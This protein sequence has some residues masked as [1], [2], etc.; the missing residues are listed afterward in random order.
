MRFDMPSQCHYPLFYH[1]NPAKESVPFLSAATLQILRG[2][3]Q[4][5]PQ[6]SLLQAK[7]PQ[8]SQPVFLGEV[9]HPLDISN[10]WQCF[11]IGHLGFF[12]N[13]IFAKKKICAFLRWETFWSPTVFPRFF[14]GILK[15]VFFKGNLSCVSICFG[16]SKLP[17][18]VLQDCKNT[19]T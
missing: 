16:G 15:R 1:S 6:P 9:F 12:F 17:E 18:L 3:S 11:H 8:L 5:S 2:Q 10:A 4:V 13:V 7:Q 19:F 14:K